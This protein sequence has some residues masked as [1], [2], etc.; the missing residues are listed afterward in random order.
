M[1]PNQ[2]CSAHLLKVI[3]VM[4]SKRQPRT[5]SKGKKRLVK[6]K[7][8][9]DE[10]LE[11]QFTETEDLTDESLVAAFKRNQDGKDE[12]LETRRVLIKAQDEEFEK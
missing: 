9:T 6:E 5:K 10:S 1:E 2:I 12:S 3:T 8:I 11:I 4:I 7:D